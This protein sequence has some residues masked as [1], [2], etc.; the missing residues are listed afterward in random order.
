MI[1]FQ[2][3]EGDETGT[4]AVGVSV[5]EELMMKQKAVWYI[6]PHLHW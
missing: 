3:E 2:Y 5:T 6:F 4:F 1:S